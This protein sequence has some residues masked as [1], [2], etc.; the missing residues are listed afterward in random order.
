[1]AL[2]FTVVRA[3]AGVTIGVIIAVFVSSFFAPYIGA[4][5]FIAF[6]TLT[7]GIGYMIARVLDVRHT[8]TKLRDLVSIAICSLIVLAFGSIV[9]G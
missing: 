7:L 2:A 5:T 3:A 9:I 4:Y 6:I 8:S 1:M